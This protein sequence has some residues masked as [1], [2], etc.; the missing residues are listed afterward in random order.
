MKKAVL[1]VILLAIPIVSAQYYYTLADYP[2]MFF[3]LREFNA[4]IVKG[5]QRDGYEKAAVNLVINSLPKDY[6][7]LRTTAYGKGYYQIRTTPQEVISKVLEE[8]DADLSKYNTI[9][10]GTPC[11]NSKVAEALMIT[12]CEAYFEP[13]EALVKL[14]E[15]NN[16]HH[17][18][19]T[20]YDG[21]MV[22]Q[23]AEYYIKY[24]YK[25]KLRT[26]EIKLKQ[27]F[28]QQRVMISDGI[29][30]IGRPIGR[31]TPSL[32]YRQPDYGRYK[33]YGGTR[34]GTVYY[35]E[36]RYRSTRDYEEQRQYL[37]FNTRGGRVVLG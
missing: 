4:R 17:L 18:V 12:D 33:T 3:D 14:V 8:K 35:G 1:L 20:G 28:K 2:H 23:A 32:Y 30:T 36:E 25:F 16:K 26:R 34:Y 13:K 15:K 7:I 31:E 27:Q 24:P 9:I 29:L 5:A 19:I 22:L 21:F 37:R 10:V 6:R 11:H